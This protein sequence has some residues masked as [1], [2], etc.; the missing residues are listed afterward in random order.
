MNVRNINPCL[1]IL[2][3]CGAL[4]SAAS[5]QAQVRTVPTMD[6]DALATA[7]HATGLTITSVRIR[8]GV[9][10]Q[11]GTYSAFD[12]PPVT[13]RPGVVLSSGDV[14]N[15]G[16]IPGATDPGYDPSTPPPQV[17]SWMVPDPD[18]GGTPEFDEYGYVAGNIEN[19]QGSFEV[20][21]LEVQFTLDQP[22]SVK[23]D[24][25]FGSVEFPFYTSSFTDSFLVFLDG[26][27]PADQI[28]FD[29]NNS[30]VQ[31][32]SSF[33]GLETT[34]DLNS[35]FSNPHALI[36]HLTTTS[37]RLE[38]GEHFIIFEVAD[39]NDHILDSAVFITNFRTGTG[40]PG[41]DPSDDCRADYN[42][43]DVVNSQ[44]FFDFLTDFFAGEGDADFNEDEAINSQ[45]FFDFLNAFFVGCAE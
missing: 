15:L 10:G 39:V 35:A 1:K 25:I 45:D 12:L 5:V 44:D 40:N 24:F 28:T 18:T 17:N 7:L 42:S 11:C 33:A 23:F 27:T 14:T 3:A 20:A 4:A 32:G 21:A 26:V 43:D 13:I 30:A 36:H 2:C 38:D 34:A 9:Q 6:V 29:A 22:S 37:P 31:V 8:N 16:P 19:F 41:T